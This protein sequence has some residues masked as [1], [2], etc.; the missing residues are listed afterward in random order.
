MSQTL[1]SALKATGLRSAKTGKSGEYDSVTVQPGEIVDLMRF[2]HDELG[3]DS[4]DCMTAV[5]LGDEF[6]LV[7]HALNYS[8]AEAVVGKARLAR[9][10]PVIES[11][12]SVYPL[13][14]WFE[15]EVLDMFGVEF[16]NHPNP[17]RMLRRDDQPGYPLRKDYERRPRIPVV[18]DAD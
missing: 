10:S 4:L 3:M 7:Y 16:T 9:T 8:N 11:V 1:S 13:A 14:N 6:E 12:C 2:F 5:D 18:E 15:R 17:T